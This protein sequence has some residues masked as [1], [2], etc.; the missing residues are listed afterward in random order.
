[1]IKLH[2][3]HSVDPNGRYPETTMAH[4]VLER[5][6]ARSNYS[7]FVRERVK[8]KR[9]CYADVII[10]HPLLDINLQDIASTTLLYAAYKAGDIKSIKYLNKRGANIHIR[11]KSGKNILY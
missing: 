7:P 8:E 10:K 3:K 1:M 2:F 4:Q 9:N 5:S 11:D 6:G